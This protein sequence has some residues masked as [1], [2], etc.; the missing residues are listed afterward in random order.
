MFIYIKQC[1]AYELEILVKCFHYIVFIILIT[2]HGSKKTGST[3]S[4]L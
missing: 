4:D 1:L 2:F 3:T